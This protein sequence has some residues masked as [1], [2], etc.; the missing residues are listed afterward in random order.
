MR[1]SAV[2][3]RIVI[4]VSKVFLDRTR[5]EIGDA[6]EI[7]ETLD[8]PFDVVFNDIDKQDYPAAL[9]LALGRLREG[10]LFISD[11]MLWQGRVLDREPVD[12]ATRGVAELTRRLY[13]SDVWSTTLV[14]LRDGVTISVRLS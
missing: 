14:P 4:S 13:A 11:N 9:D 6:L 2:R 1:V 12:P 7:A 5:I 8:G 3:W 10:G